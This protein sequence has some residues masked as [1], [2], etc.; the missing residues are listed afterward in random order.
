[1]KK[2]IQLLVVVF[3]LSAI[4]TISCKEKEPT[5]EPTETLNF[6]FSV[7]NAAKQVAFT[8]MINYG[9]VFLWDFGDG[10]TSNEKNPVHIYAAAGTYAVKLS[11]STREEKKEITKQVTVGSLN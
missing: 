9:D 6:F 8:A 4:A 1:M 7:D 2:S 3:V 10:N 5:P 11:V